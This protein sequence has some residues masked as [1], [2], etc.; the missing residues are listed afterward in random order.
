MRATVAAST[1]QRRRMVEEGV[2]DL[3]VPLD[4]RGVGFLDFDHVGQIAARG[5]EQTLPQ[6][7]EWLARARG[8]DKEVDSRVAP[9][10]S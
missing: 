1:Q 9:H 7:R 4:L 3:Y 5:Y 8:A 6:L 10:T 2:I